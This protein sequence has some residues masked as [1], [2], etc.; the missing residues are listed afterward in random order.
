[1]ATLLAVV[2]LTIAS[3]A[4]AGL[5]LTEV[6]FEKAF[7]K[8]A[9]SVAMKGLRG[10]APVGDQEVHSQWDYP[11]FENPAVVTKFTDA[12]AV[13]ETLFVMACSSKHKNDV[14][15]MARDKAKAEAFNEK[16]FQAYVKKLQDGNIAEMKDRCGKINTKSSL[17]CRLGCTERWA[18]GTS[19]FSLTM[20]KNRCV[21]RC[22]KK[23]TNWETECD[24]KVDEL[25]NVFLTEQGNL[26][27][28]KKCVEIHCKEFPEVLMMDES[29]GETRKEEGCGEFCTEKAIKGR[30]A[31]RW[32]L[33]VDTQL[34][35]WQDEC[36]DETKAGTLDPCM[37]DGT[38]TADG[39]QDTCKTEGADKCETAFTDCK[40]EGEA[41]GPDSMVG[42]NAESICGVRK[43]VC[44]TQVDAK[45][46]KEHQ[47]SL[48]DLEKKCME[49]HKKESKACLKK[50]LDDGEKD[51]EDTCKA[52]LEPTCKD[53][54]KE[55]CQLA[56][57]NQCKDDMIKQSFG[58]TGEYCGQLWKWM[59]DSE[60]VDK[61]TGDAI[62]KT[63]SYRFKTIGRKKLGDSK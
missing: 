39:D 3:S 59:F 11:S 25:A 4:H 60:Y 54:C 53:D 62:P 31:K 47:S 44:V 27:N 32:D 23:H 20:E 22:E 21:D 15:G 26:A 29:E 19:S 2:L 13:Q 36:H 42:A 48:G 14:D 35:G 9:G 33:T 61:K 41:A 24:L 17:Q 50:K 10:G 49:D 52:D 55:D 16:E 46:Q 5:L 6:H 40:A 38:G 37:S 45:C 1:M 28:T 57:M 63:E 51:F 43:N 58:L 8:A 34:A 30:C 7:E 56:D 12:E 18:N